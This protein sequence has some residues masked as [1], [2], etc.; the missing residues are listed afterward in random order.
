MWKRLGDMLI[1]EGLITLDQLKKALAEQKDKGGRL[2]SLLVQMNFVTD[3]Q[4]SMTL[5]K[6]YNVG[7]V[8][9][10]SEIDQMTLK[11]VSP[12]IAQKFQVIPVRREGKNLYLAM[13]NPVDVYTIEDI[14]FATGYNVVPMVA[15]ENLIAQA[16]EKYY[17]VAGSMSEVLSEMGI[18]DD[19]IEII[20]EE[21]QPDAQQLLI[22]VDAAPVVKL[23]NGIIVEAV[24]QGASDIHIEPF[25]KILRVRYRVDGELKEVMS[26]QYTMGAAITSRLKIMSGLNIS[27]RRVPQD[28][29]IGMKVAEKSIDL[30]VS[31]LPTAHGEKICMRIAEKSSLLRLEDIGLGRKAYNDFIEAIERPNG[32]ILVTGP[33]GSGKTVT[34]YSVLAR[35]NTPNV[36]ITTAEDPIEYDFVGINQVN[37]RENI[38]YTFATALKAFLR[39]DPDIIM[40]GEIRDL[41]TGDIAIKAAL[42]GHVVLSTLHTNDTIS[43]ISRMQDM[44]IAAYKVASAVV[45]I[46]AQRLIRRVCKYCGQQVDVSDDELIKY[47]VNPEYMRGAKFMMGK[48]CMQCGN[49]GYKGRV[50]IFEVLPLTHTLREMIV[51]GAAADELKMQARREGVIMLREDGLIKVKAGITT[52]EEVM[53]ATVG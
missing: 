33:T 3:E 39:Q 24:R 2:G 6:Q 27:E 11:I 1:D 48:G 5:G 22:D 14:K 17:G 34:L 26:P 37:V 4:I 23:V 40:V 52:L 31:T 7:V 49:T 12:Q 47:G 10:D 32:I 42:T 43:T 51:K 13:A 50:G 38:G 30:R 25:E 19:D 28:G 41:D 44:G 9:F 29:R 35:M 36:N 16:I 46:E 53:K 8:S 18:D 45:L 21:K 15:S 20:E